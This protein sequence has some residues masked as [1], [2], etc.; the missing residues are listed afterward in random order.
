MCRHKEKK[1]KKR[2][3]GRGPKNIYLAEVVCARWQIL[4][5]LGTNVGRG[6]RLWFCRLDRQNFSRGCAESAKQHRPRGWDVLQTL[7]EHRQVSLI[8]VTACELFVRG[9][10]R[11]QPRARQQDVSKAKTQTWISKSP[12][13]EQHT[14]YHETWPTLNTA[15]LS[16][17]TP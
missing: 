10:V 5:D 4:A 2:K 15:R 11:A 6:K 12:D 7:W 3:E 13:K 8:S 9:Q 1:K 14:F 16:Q 17:P